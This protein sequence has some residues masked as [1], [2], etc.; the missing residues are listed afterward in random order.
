[1]KRGAWIGVCLGLAVAL[2][3]M[4]T[5]DRVAV[6][7]RPTAG[8]ERPKT[9]SVETTR[10]EKAATEEVSPILAE[11]NRSAEPRDDVR[12]FEEAFAA[13]RTNF[14]GRGN[15]V[16]DNREITAA[17]AGANPLAF[18]FLDPRHPAINADGELCDRWGT[19]WRFHAW[20]GDDLEPWSAG[21]DL[22]FATADDVR[23]GEREP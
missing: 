23:A 8:K 3:L 10:K 9:L 12:L 4:L 20:R 2:W 17:L 6:E 22:R 19:P 13:W 18:R 15:P 21:P 14:P 16:G 11:L 7:P 1:M 5:R